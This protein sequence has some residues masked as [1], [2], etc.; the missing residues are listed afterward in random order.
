MKWT[1]EKANKWYEDKG[2]IFGFNFVPKTAVNAT[3]M[4][5]EKTFDL[6][7]IEK[8]LNL[9]KET[10]F[11]SCRVFLSYVV[12]KEEKDKYISRFQEFLSVAKKY[13][14]TVMPIL[15]DDCAFDNLC[16]PFYGEQYEPRIGVHNSRWTPSP[17]FKLADDK[18]E[19]PY[20]EKYLKDFVCAFKNEENIL[21]WD[22]YNEP[23][24]SGR[25]EKCLELVRNAFQWARE[26][27][28]TQPL[29][30][31]RFNYKEYETE[32]YELSDVISLHTYE[33]K[34]GTL[35][36]I[37]DAEKYG[38]PVFCTEWLH[39]ANGSTFE[40]LLEV[41]KEKRIGIY[42][43]G[44]V[45]GKTQTNLNWDT[46]PKGATPNP[47]PILWQHDLFNEDYTPY[48]P[49]EIDFINKVLKA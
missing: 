16:E 5:Q 2:F 22:L 27:E 35:K 46:M 3:D 33:N 47:N 29:T 42:N 14:I 31:G 20:L 18:N 6:P 21:L 8:E 38:R 25:N 45:K 1:N 9:A 4:W 10:G 37:T 30:A 49:E 28:P 11:N 7:Q 32:F 48:K 26:C 43:W 39:R 24:N 17:G 34:E 15:F 23:G 13:N 36:K 44:L 12:W 19:L 40:E 41:F